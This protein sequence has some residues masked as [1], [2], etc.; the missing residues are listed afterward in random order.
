M[1]YYCKYRVGMGG[2]GG[3]GGRSSDEREERGHLLGSINNAVLL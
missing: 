2:K 1:Y 3:E